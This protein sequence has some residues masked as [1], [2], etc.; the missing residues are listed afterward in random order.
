M[1]NENDFYY[2]AEVDWTEGRAGGLKSSGLPTLD[3]AAPPEF[4]GRENTWT[5]EHLYVGSVASCFMTTFLAI[6]EL[7]KLEFR[8]LSVKAEGRL[9]RAEGSGYEMT[10]IILR[11]TLVV[12]YGRDL[13]RAS[14][15]LEKAEKKCLIS[16]SIKTKVK[17]EPRVYNEQSP[18]YPC[19]PVSPVTIPA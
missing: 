11:P 13:E 19:P 18:A 17:L 12:R 15:M 16:N 2:Q 3:V 8:S 7:S 5:P 4:Q 1:R 10:E 9:K 14:R 6:A